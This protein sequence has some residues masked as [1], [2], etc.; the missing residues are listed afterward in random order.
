ML[1]N[2]SIEK[3]DPLSKEISTSKKNALKGSGQE[4]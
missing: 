1:S 2:E 4:K 3:T